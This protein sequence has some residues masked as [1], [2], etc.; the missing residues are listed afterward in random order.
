[1]SKMKKILSFLLVFALLFSV[2]PA[3]AANVE[4]APEA[5]VAGRPIRTE[6]VSTGP[7]IGASGLTAVDMDAVR[8]QR[9]PN[10]AGAERV[11]LSLMAETSIMDYDV[12]GSGISMEGL[13]EEDAYVLEIAESLTE[14]AGLQMEK[15]KDTVDV[16][17]WLSQLPDALE[18]RYTTMGVQDVAYEQAKADA[19]AA[20]ISLNADTKIEVT[21]NYNW[22]FAGLAATVPADYLDTLAAMPGVYCITADM[23]HEMEY[24]LDPGYATPGNLGARDL[25]RLH[26][27]HGRGI[28]GTGVN[29]C[30]MDSGIQATSGGTVASHPD[31]AAAFKGG[32]DYRG[33]A[34]GTPDGN[35]GTHV[36]GT[37]ASQGASS[38]GM[39]PGVNLYIAQIFPSATQSKVLAAIEDITQS[40]EPGG[41]LP[42]MDVVNCSFGQTGN[43]SAYDAEAYQMN[44]AALIG[45]M[46][47]VSAGNYGRRQTDSYAG[48]N[49]RSS[50]TVNAPSSAAT[51]GISVAASEYGG[52]GLNGRR[53]TLE[54]RVFDVVNEN[55]DGLLP[56]LTSDWFVGKQYYVCMTGVPATG[57][58]VT[59][60]AMLNSLP[61]LNGKILVVGRGIEFTAYWNAAVSKGAGGVI[62][63]NRDE[64]FITNMGWTAT[65]TPSAFATMPAFSAKVSAYTSVFSN[66]SNGATTPAATACVSF[67]VPMANQVTG[68]SSIGPVQQTG[69]IKPD[70]IA[71]G[72]NILS[73]DLNGGYTYMGGTSMAAPCIT[74]LY[75][76]LKQQYPTAT[77]A[78]LKARLMNTADPFALNPSAVYPAADGNTRSQISVWEQGAGFVNPV[79]AVDT[80]VI[81]TVANNVT[82]GNQSSGYVAGTMASFSFHQQPANAITP[83][84]VATVTGASSFTATSLSRDNTRYSLSSAGVVTPVITPLSATTFSVAL[85]I[86]SSAAQGLYE[87]Y[88]RVTANG[89]DYYLPWGVR[90]G[91][92]VITPPEGPPM[93]ID[94]PWLIFPD[95]P[96]MVG[97]GNDAIADDVDIS[98][99]NTVYL[100]FESLAELNAVDVITSGGSSYFEIFLLK[101]PNTS[102]ASFGYKYRVNLGG[103]YSNLGEFYATRGWAPSTLTQI[104]IGQV[105]DYYYTATNTWS[106]TPAASLRVANGNYMLGLSRNGG[107]VGYRTLF[108]FVVSGSRPTV[109]YYNAASTPNATTFG[110]VDVTTNNQTVYMKPYPKGATEATIMGAIMSPAIKAGYDV[111]FTWCGAFLIQTGELYYVNHGFNAFE[112]RASATAPFGIG[113]VD[114]DNFICYS[115]TT[116]G[117]FAFT[118]PVSSLSTT[119]DG[120]GNRYFFNYSVNSG[121]VT[122][123]GGANHAAYAVDGFA[124]RWWDGDDYNDPN[125]YTA[126][127][128][129]SANTSVPYVREHASIGP[130][131]LQL[132]TNVPAAI[133]AGAP[134]PRWETRFTAPY[135]GI[136]TFTSLNNGSGV[137]QRDPIAWKE[138]GFAYASNPENFWGDEEA[139]NANY[140]FTR[141]MT[142]GE[143]FIYWTG[144][145]G[146]ALTTAGNYDV[147][148]TGVPDPLEP[149]ELILNTRVPVEIISAGRREVFFIAPEEGLY[150]FSAH[151]N[152][153]SNLSDNINDSEPYVAATGTNRYL[154]DGSIG[155]TW[156][157]EA[158]GYHY[159]F[160]QYLT[161]GQKFTYWSGVYDSVGVNGI[162]DV[163]VCFPPIHT[164]TGEE[165]TVDL[166]TFNLAS[167]TVTW[168]ISLNEVTTD[169]PLSGYGLYAAWDDTE[170]EYVSH[171]VVGSADT[172]Y[173]GSGGAWFEEYITSG[174]YFGSWICDFDEEI[175]WDTEAPILTITFKV[176]K[177]NVADGDVFDITVGGSS[178]PL[179][180]MFICLWSEFEDLFSVESEGRLILT[181]GYIDFIGTPPVTAMRGDANCDGAVDAADAAAILRFLAGLSDLSDQGAINAEVTDVTPLLPNRAAITAE[182]AAKILRYLANIITV[183]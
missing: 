12:L 76:L 96:T 60:Q 167:D 26:E 16:I 43:N 79:R 99:M 137:T 163:K 132:D 57:Q 158:D 118:L 46:F 91:A 109:T 123:G 10:P 107:S 134:N 172:A 175:N 100:Q 34:L 22:V 136:F 116:N 85:D 121:V 54:G 147:R 62:C 21:H 49:Y 58:T 32:W 173:V 154:G 117:M 20:R 169:M 178:D 138:N 106:T 56:A 128:A 83:A 75:A 126:G 148:V 130:I 36:A 6:S 82:N 89:E 110:A 114:D 69:A 115:S 87:G 180:E 156:N 11:D 5:Q 28:V 42:K 152:S 17:I 112:Y 19:K 68:F 166:A 47:V 171:T 139:G 14:P 86:A 33:Y 38:L 162:Y 165:K 150:T 40:G 78:Q 144:L 168:S 15:G 103:T 104:T 29:V 124:P 55:S 1:M 92:A 135:T 59:T 127:H 7:T 174:S 129:F 133:T 122:H 94:V 50:Y 157:D 131:I 143:T 90:V 145:Y 74:G 67:S 97:Y 53:A 63:I 23:E 146:S 149:I 41:H 125:Y 153:S 4:Q 164:L 182:D 48:D 73:T 88:I 13:S 95:H 9:I 18:P 65:G 44:N 51:F 183:L 101:R 39:A 155:T 70:I 140:Q 111:L 160:V 93:V 2:V 177:A 151:T 141:H 84:I 113:I 71:P 159:A 102:S 66:Y 25:F 105:A 170:L 24:T 179:D 81:I 35:H 98:T 8:A 176:V 45:T 119:Q 108:G 181:D 37:I 77:T 64:D 120:S 161:E 27:L 61:A 142:A 30:V 31:L 52:N 80:N 3:L 72:E